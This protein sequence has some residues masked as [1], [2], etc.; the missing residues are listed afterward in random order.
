MSKII[1]NLKHIDLFGRRVNLRFSSSD[2]Y[3]THC[4][5]C[6]SFTLIVTILSVF[7]YDLNSIYFGKLD[8]I[9]FMIKNTKKE[10]LSWKKS[11]IQSAV[12][13]IAVKD[14]LLNKEGYLELE[15]GIT[16]SGVNNTVS[17]VYDCSNEVYNRMIGKT[18]ELVPKGMKILCFNTTSDYIDQHFYP[19]FSLKICRDKAVCRK[20][21]K[22]NEML[23]EIEVWAFTLV[24]ETD[25]TLSKTNL[26]SS[27]IGKKIVGSKSF[28]KQYTMYVR[29]VEI[30]NNQGLL[31]RHDNI[32]R[33]IQYLKGR[34]E[35]VSIGDPHY[36]M[37]LKLKLEQTQKL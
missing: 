20:K 29:E 21:K 17:I 22:L 26:N 8:K 25:H 11:D 4:G 1:D 15:H 31:S 30:H 3:K 24:D 12:F 9:S 28:T 35:I 34:T 13:G 14:N 6:A 37:Q 16:R 5:A 19:Y 18:A 7:F 32:K 2:Y 10:T 36:L 23:K 33:T 27:F